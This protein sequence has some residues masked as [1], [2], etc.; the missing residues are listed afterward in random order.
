MTTHHTQDLNGLKQRL[1]TM[2]GHAESAVTRAVKA[3]VERDDDLARAVQQDD[4]ILDSF[5]MEIDEL[6]ILLLTKAPLASDLRLI[7]VAMKISHDLERVG[8]EATTIS[9]RAMQLNREPQ[10]KQADVI[11]V[12]AEAGMAMLKDALD[13][14]VNRDAAKARAVVP[15][16]KEVDRLNKQFHRDTEAFMISRN[17][18]IPQCLNLMV[19]SKSLERVA[20]HA[21]NIAEEVVYLYEAADIRH[22]GKEPVAG[23]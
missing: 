20:D 16:D 4:T 12:M 18:A 1:L 17:E 8:D 11:P 7:T 23:K 15:R 22:T 5:E 21:T 19:V 2:A 6:C 14:F 13:S 10:L 9:R 3:L